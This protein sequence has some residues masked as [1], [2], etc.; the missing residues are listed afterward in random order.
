MQPYLKLYYRLDILIIHC[1]SNRVSLSVGCLVALI[2]VQFSCCSISPSGFPVIV[3]AIAWELTF[4][5]KTFSYVIRDSYGHCS[6]VPEGQ[7]HACRIEGEQ[8]S[9]C[10]SPS[11]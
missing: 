11:R 1:D 10:G 8:E 5:I 2:R 9:N 3:Q 6:S 7:F 4:P